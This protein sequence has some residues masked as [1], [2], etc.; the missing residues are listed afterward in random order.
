ML[1]PLIF[2][3]CAFFSADVI[4]VDVISVDRI[5]GVIFLLWSIYLCQCINKKNCSEVIG[6]LS[7]V[8]FPTN[9]CYFYPKFAWQSWNQI[10]NC[11]LFLP[12][13]FWE[14]TYACWSKM[15]IRAV[16]SKLSFSWIQH[17]KKNFLYWK[18]FFYYLKAHDTF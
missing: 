11:S 2:F 14:C 7:R 10:N 5:L 3:C 6:V 1:F 4:S 12:P 13:D 15:W 17:Q 8:F 18:P 16:F 9:I